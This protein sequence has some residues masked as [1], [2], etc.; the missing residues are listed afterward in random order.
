[1]VQVPAMGEGAKFQAMSC[2]SQHKIDHMDHIVTALVQYLKFQVFPVCW[3][4]DLFC[5]SFANIL[6]QFHSK[7][8]I[9]NVG[10]YFLFLR[11]VSSKVNFDWV[12]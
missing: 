12:R 6:L 5:K 10:K 8:L 3:S 11:R 9:V 1:V 4:T 2:S 7:F